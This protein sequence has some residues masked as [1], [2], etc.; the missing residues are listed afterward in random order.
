MHTVI[1]DF[2]TATHAANN[3]SDAVI[4]QSSFHHRIGFN[5]RRLAFENWALPARYD[6]T[7]HPVR[8]SGQGRFSRESSILPVPGRRRAV[9]TLR[10]FAPFPLSA[11]FASGL[12][13]GC[14]TIESGT[15]AKVVLDG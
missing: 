10:G 12:A 9:L 14:V 13:E 11:G 6:E 2:L 8:N 5:E 1:A 4:F 7:F 3:D 15:E